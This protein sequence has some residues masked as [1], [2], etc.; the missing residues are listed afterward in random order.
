MPA[1]LL[2]RVDIRER[3]PEA[4]LDRAAVPLPPLQCTSL[5]PRA[6]GYAYVLRNA[7]APRTAG[8]TRHRAAPKQV[9]GSRA[10][11][12]RDGTPARTRPARRDDAL[13]QACTADAC[14]RDLR[15]ASPAPGRRTR[16]CAP[17]RCPG[18]AP[19]APRYP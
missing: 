4:D 2:E 7:L 12:A 9:S 10:R 19:R 5:E 8:A 3:A 16:S 13:R 1:V 17:R 11:E 18:F 6:Q 15:P 14:G